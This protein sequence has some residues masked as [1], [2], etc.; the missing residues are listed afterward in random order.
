MA[1]ARLLVHCVLLAPS[2]SA[3]ALPARRV[4]RRAALHAAAA[5]TLGATATACGAAYPMNA[6]EELLQEKVAQR[7]AAQEKEL[8]FKFEPE[9]VAEVE[10]ILRNK[11]CG[12]AGLYGQMEGGS[13][14][15]VVIEAAYCTKADGR[16]S[17]SAGCPPPPKQRPPDTG[18]PKLPS[19]PTSLSSLPS[20]PF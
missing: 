8:G 11:Y 9:D 19:L 12:K 15:E 20:L 1:R 16:M 5:A 3:L 18:P 4:G 2:V 10:T 17:S 6:A 13:C 7:V 14:A